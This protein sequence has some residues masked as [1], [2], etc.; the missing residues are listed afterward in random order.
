MP[1]KRRSFRRHKRKQEQGTKRHKRKH[2]KRHKRKQGTKRRKQEQGTKRRKQEHTKRNKRGGGLNPATDE[3]KT[4]LNFIFNE[5]TYIV[6]F[7]QELKN[8]DKWDIEQSIINDTGDIV[9]IVQFSMNDWPTL[10]QNIKTSTLFPLLDSNIDLNKSVNSIY[11]YFPVF[12][13][14]NIKLTKPGMLLDEKIVIPSPTPS[15]YSD[16]EKRFFNTFYLLEDVTNKGNFVSD[17]GFISDGVEVFDLASSQGGQKQRGGTELTQDQPVA[18][19]KPSIT[20]KVLEVVPNRQGLIGIPSV[21]NNTGGTVYIIKIENEEEWQNV[22][23]LGALI[24]H[25]KNSKTYQS[26]QYL[27]SLK[28]NQGIQLYKNIFPSSWVESVFRNYPE[29]SH[30]SDWEKDVSFSKDIL[31]N[32]MLDLEKKQTTEYK[33]T[34]PYFPNLNKIQ[35]CDESETDNS[36]YDDFEVNNFLNAFYNFTPRERVLGLTKNKQLYLYAYVPKANQGFFTKKPSFE[37]YFVKFYNIIKNGE[38]YKVGGDG[39]DVMNDTGKDVFIVQ[40]VNQIDRPNKADLKWIEQGSPEDS[41][42]FDAS[43]NLFPSNMTNKNFLPLLK[44]VENPNI[45]KV[46]R[47]IDIEL[48]TKK[49]IE[50]GYFPV[51]GGHNLKLVDEHGLDEIFVEPNEKP[52]EYNTSELK[53]FYNFYGL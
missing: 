8:G 13:N 48:D 9:Y 16:L 52:D 24:N 50:N 25:I 6:R 5:K 40:V 18:F 51:F 26:T 11:K 7:I 38:P 27:M 12:K 15:D 14:R 42:I 17:A 46:S 28:K 47:R 10:L 3:S 37:K 1:P 31:W 32:F 33:Y 30:A 21:V 23:R 45:N 49:N 22:M 41:I 2:T 43:L 20:G 35:R 53:F 34:F 44:I 29:I 39:I 36:T 4:L 19:C